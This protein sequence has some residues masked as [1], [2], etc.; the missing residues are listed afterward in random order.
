M[1]LAAW[2]IIFG[3]QLSASPAGPF[4]MPLYSS[5]M[6]HHPIP[7]S[8]DGS[9]EPDHRGS[10]SERRLLERARRGSRAA[11]DTLFTRYASWLRVWARGRLPRWVRG[12]L[13]TSDLVQDALHHTFA[14]LRWF[15]S[16]HASALRAYL[17][18]A[19]ENRVRD[20]L[21]RAVYR[22]ARDSIM[23]AD[24]VRPFE[25]AAPQFEQLMDAETW[26]RYLEGLKHLTARDRRLIVGRAELGYNY[27]QLALIESMPSADAARKATRRAVVRLIG[28]MPD[29]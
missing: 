18:R 25:D 7:P 15:E 6:I 10:T 17:R 19:V 14:R 13:D 23:P 12:A 2:V 1:T 21:R 29:V 22:R 27:R 4:P 9:G 8:S 26:G 24:P 20:E 11:L 28:A 5:C 3:G 16:K